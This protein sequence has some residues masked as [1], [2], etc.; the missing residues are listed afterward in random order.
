[1]S[2]DAT[3]NWVEKA[4]GHVEPLIEQ[5]AGV[6]V[7][8]RPMPVS[9]GTIILDMAEKLRP[10]LMNV[11]TGLRDENGMLVQPSRIRAIALNVAQ[12]I[13]TQQEKKHS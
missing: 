3:N 4:K 13:V 5:P 8:K 12:D 1:M 2:N 6:K 11:L 10:W 9:K 7:V